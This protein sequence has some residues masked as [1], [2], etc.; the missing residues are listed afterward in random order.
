MIVDKP[1]FGAACNVVGT[2][3]RRT[4]PQTETDV[5]EL[6]GSAA[7][8][9]GVGAV[10]QPTP[11]TASLSSDARQGERDISPRFETRIKG[12]VNVPL[13]HVVMLSFIPPWCSSSSASYC[14]TRQTSIT[15]KGETRTPYCCTAA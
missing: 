10:I 13:A 11:A 15:E 5:L 8:A 2:Y 14:P 12:G 3:Y 4:R 1:F 7:P 6:L 9:V